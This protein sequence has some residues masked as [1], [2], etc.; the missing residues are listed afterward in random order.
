MGGTATCRVLLMVVLAV[1]VALF[2]QRQRAPATTGGGD[3]DRAISASMTDP[4]AVLGVPRAA[5]KEVVTKAY[6]RLAKRFH[7]DRNRGD[8]AAAIFATLAAAYETLTDPEKR[9]IFD[10][11]GESGLERL[12]DGDPSVRKDWL[13][14]DEVLRR[15][16]NDGDEPW[17]DYMV[18]SSFAAFA[19]LLARCDQHVSP[20]VRW[21][22]GTD[23][24]S[25]RITATDASGAALAS[26]GSTSGAVTFRFTLSGLSTDF[27]ES[28]VVQQNCERP[29]FLGMKASYYLQCE[30]ARGRALS[31]S[32]TA[33]SFTVSSRVG[34]NAAS[35]LFSLNMV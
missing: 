32:V 3:D 22:A 8:S 21:L 31:V 15:I 23:V 10:R 1:G 11:L 6:R 26:G 33:G 35:D 13:P 12:R 18:T 34:S 14:P 5:S 28:D 4:Y 27:A 16:H 30:Y 20:V 9:D 25:V 24:P 17:F 19:S 7:P 29:R 2:R